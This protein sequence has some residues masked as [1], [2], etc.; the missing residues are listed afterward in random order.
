MFIMRR[1]QD[2]TEVV[3]FSHKGKLSYGDLSG[4]S[5]AEDLIRKNRNLVSAHIDDCDTALRL[6]L[7]DAETKFG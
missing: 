2:K 7:N 1:A 3:K 4:I 6:N 5:Y